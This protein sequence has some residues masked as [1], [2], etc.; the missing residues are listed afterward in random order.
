MTADRKSAGLADIFKYAL[1]EGVF[2]IAMNG[3][4]SFSMIFLTQIL[5]LNPAWASLSISISLLWDAVTDPVMGH[6]SDNTRSRWGRRHPFI[7]GGGLVT[8]VFFFLFWS[9]PQLLS[10]PAAIFAAVLVINLLIR[11]AI[12][13]YTVPYTA[14]GFE[15]CPDYEDR[16]RVQGARYFIS[17]TTNFIFVAGAW[18][19]FFKDG[20]DAS[21]ERVDGSLI[22]SNYV[23]MGAVLATFIAVIVSVC[24][25]GTRRY[26]VDNRS[27]AVHKN[28]F[29]AFRDDFA[30]I[31]KDRL[32]V[33]VFLFFIVAML[34]IMLMGQVQMF[35]YIFYMKFNAVEKTGVHGAG[36]L[37]FAIAALSLSRVV[38]RMDKKPAGYLAIG[39]SMFGGLGL[40]A[41]FTGGLLEPQQ[42][43]ALFGLSVPVATIVFG[44]FQMCWWGGCGLLVP[45]VSSMVADV[46]AIH[47]KETGELKNAGYA[48]V[49]S[50]CT[51]AAQAVGMLI[52][53]ALVGAAGIISG[54][55]EQTPEAV[56][57]ISI[58]TFVN[59]PVVMLL[60]LL[61]LRK[62]PVTREFMEKLENE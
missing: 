26:A 24:S 36:M 34:A 33:H 5:G 28:N 18:A 54:V 40:L 45:L 62:Y 48:S 57:N 60:A 16:A 12:T 37:A 25:F 20:A 58:M 3:A 10:N 15:I 56:R 6:I 14:L 1:G 38:R 29:K 4:N 59:G 13:V 23:V 27:E 50:F 8:A 19:L 42:K 44:L 46:A 61:I 51:K 39:L 55:A 31:F 49:F 17:Q 43:L 21:G 30:S 2:S 32:A 11:T 9:L 52:C 47:E 35:T 53:G 22:A 41:V 7:L